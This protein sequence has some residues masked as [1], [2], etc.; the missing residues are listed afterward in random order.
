MDDKYLG[1]SYDLVKRFFWQELREI[2]PLYA[3]PRF[4]PKQ[5][6]AKFSL[7][8]KIPML[9]EV[10]SGSDFGLLL[11]PD[12]GIK[13]PGCSCS[14]GN[15]KHVSLE[16][17][18]EYLKQPP[19]PKYIVCF[20]QNHHRKSVLSPQK[21]R[22]CKMKFLQENVLHSFYYASHAPFLF[23][24]PQEDTLRLIRERLSKAGI[25]LCKIQT[26]EPS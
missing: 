2:A 26:Y 14:K 5:I 21:Q 19:T 3:D 25:P 24:T 1:D 23:V 12:T 9:T 11:D 4:V 16:Q 13:A 18:V 20:D 15:K 8:T 10:P 22:A 7:I 17:I 6:R